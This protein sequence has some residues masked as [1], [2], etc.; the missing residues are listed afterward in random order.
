MEFST[1]MNESTTSLMEAKGFAGMDA[2]AESYTSLE[3]NRGQLDSSLTEM[4][5][6]LN[7]PEELTPEN[8]AAMFNRLG[9]P[10]D[11]SGYEVKYE[12]D[13]KLDDGLVNS[14]KEFALSKNIPAGTFN[15]LV[16]FQ[17]DAVT[18]ATTTA[19]DA[20][21]VADE[22][23]IVADNDAI[24]ASEASLMAELGDKYESSMANAAEASKALGLDDL[25][26]AAGKGSDPAWL[27]QLNVI[28]SKLSEGT[29]KGNKEQSSEGREG[30][31]K[32]L[33]ESEA[34][35]NSMHSGH[36]AAHARY[37][38]LHGIG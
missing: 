26:E 2:F 37:N 3:T 19:N 4:K 30:E 24:K 28:S 10:A 1:E 31:L 22:A 25:I 38:K 17:I 32:T 33:I 14:F 13:A 6:S 34:F 7:I 8:T 20:Q 11:V 5:G 16:N 35:K 21:K 36:K 12:G 9:V 27:K 23:K 18:A 29:L 15:E